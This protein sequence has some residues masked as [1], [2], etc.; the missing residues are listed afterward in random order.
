MTEF[1]QEF[2]DHGLHSAKTDAREIAE[3]FEVEMS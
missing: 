2:R 3:R 1:L